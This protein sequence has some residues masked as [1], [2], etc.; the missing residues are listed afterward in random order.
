MEY[1]T[2]DVV[3]YKSSIQYSWESKKGTYIGKIMKIG[4]FIVEIKLISNNKKYNK[5]YQDNHIRIWT[6]SINDII[7]KLTP[8][9]AMI[10][11]L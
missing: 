1:K 8:E 5:L 7:R 9:E 11:E 6:Y 10:E 2:G 4:N 3:L